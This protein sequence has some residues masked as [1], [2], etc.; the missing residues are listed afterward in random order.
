[1]ELLSLLVLVIV[2]GRGSLKTEKVNPEKETVKP[3]TETALCISTV[4]QRRLAWCLPEDYDRKKPPFAERL[5]RDSNQ[6]SKMNIHYAFSIR[7][8]SE[9]VDNEQ[10]LQLPMYFS[11]AWREDRLTVDSGHPAWEGSITGPAN[12]STED[13]ETLKL[14]WKP[15]LEIYGLQEFKKHSILNQ[16][17]GLR[18]S[19]D[20]VITYDIKATVEISCQMNFDNYPFDDHVC[21]FQV[22]SYFYDKNSVTCTSEFYD[23][24]SSKSNIVQRNLQH[25]VRFR[26]LRT[27]KRVVKLQSG[28]YAACGFEV[29]LERKHQPLIY[30]IYIPCILFVTV[31]WI[32]FIID[33]KVIPG[34]M[35][36]LVIL[37]LV[38]INVF[39]NVRS[40]AP[41]SGSSELNAID[42]FI[43]TCI[44]MIFSAII[45]YALVLSIYTLELDKIDFIINENRPNIRD[46][47]LK[48]IKN[49]RRLDLLSFIV[50][51]CAFILYN[52]N[53]WVIEE[54]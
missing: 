12:Q 29:L 22:G 48:M 6:A 27:S 26:K 54:H 20:K 41:S 19:R 39:N 13:A 5:S 40:S 14:F 42:G 1:M 21:T 52:F 9:V 46:R 8:V 44:F 51:S 37:F 28:E 53:Y 32:S 15:N 45:E 34:R 43:M 10:T 16:M 38:I 3:E 31:S 36:L 49:P 7:E 24:G 11:V 18:I 4:S 30:Q 2:M 50:F 33:P 47:I 25:S 35:S 23:P 17:A